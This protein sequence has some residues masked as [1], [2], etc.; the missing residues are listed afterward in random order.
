[1]VVA[2]LV[3]HLHEVRLGRHDAQEIVIDEVAGLLV[4]MA[5]VP[6]SPLFLMLGF[7][8]F[9]AFDIL[10]PYPISY[11]DKNIPGRS[12]RGGG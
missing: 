12:G 6:L 9:R 10:K 5:W 3:A 1:M 11:L 7:V 2:V 4:T 8:L